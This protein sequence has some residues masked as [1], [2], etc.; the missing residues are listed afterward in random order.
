VEYEPGLLTKRIQQHGDIYWR[1]ERLFLSEALAGED[2]AFEPSTDGFWR[3][4]FGP[5]RL[6]KLDERKRLI[7][8]LTAED[9]KP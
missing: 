9:L 6:A 4:R 3:I 7:K 2:V 8:E 5:L 1:G